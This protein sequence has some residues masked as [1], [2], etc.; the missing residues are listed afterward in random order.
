MLWELEAGFDGRFTAPFYLLIVSQQVDHQNLDIWDSPSTLADRQAGPAGPVAM[1]F[2]PQRLDA[3]PAQRRAL[4][5]LVVSFPIIF[6]FG[7]WLMP[8]LI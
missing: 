7:W 4:V 3:G 5:V 8:I 6:L 2:L 1:A